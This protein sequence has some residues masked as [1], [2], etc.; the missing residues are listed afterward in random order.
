MGEN[1]VG[2]RGG[3]MLKITIGKLG[4][5][6]VLQCRGRIV[7]GEECEVLRRAGLYNYGRTLLLDLAQ[8]DRIDAGGLGLLMEL[9]CRAVSRGTR[10]KLINLTPQ[11]EQ[12]LELTGLARVFEVCTVVDWMALLLGTSKGAERYEMSP[13]AVI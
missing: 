13:L 8:V 2:K 1:L 7:V 4:Q 6:T 10:L 12:A 5:A 9:R 3:S 11:V